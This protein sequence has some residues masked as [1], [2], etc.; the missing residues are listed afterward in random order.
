VYFYDLGYMLL[1]NIMSAL[2][3]TT[4]TKFNNTTTATTTA[5]ATATA[6]TTTT[7]TTDGIANSTTVHKKN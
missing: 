1:S 3:D 5:A 7:T 4:L 2:C 6:I